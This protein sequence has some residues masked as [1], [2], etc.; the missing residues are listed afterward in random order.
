VENQ[1]WS[2]ALR[3]DEVFSFAVV[4]DTAPDEALRRMGAEPGQISSGTWNELQTRVNEQATDVMDQW[5]LAAFRLN[6]HTL[7]VEGRPTFVNA[8]FTGIPSAI[9]D[10]TTAFS[11]SF[12]VESM[13]NFQILVDGE[14]VANYGENGDLEPLLPVVG[15][16]LTAMGEGADQVLTW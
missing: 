7:I 16:A 1:A 6:G 3:L 5:V 12:D 13:N 11:S 4:L 14:E 9:S 15:S 8:P 10:G 2:S